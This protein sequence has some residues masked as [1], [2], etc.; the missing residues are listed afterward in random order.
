MSLDPTRSSALWADIV[1]ILPLLRAPYRNASHAR[2]GFF[3]IRWNRSDIPTDGIV[4]TTDG[5]TTGE[6][7]QHGYW[8]DRVPTGQVDARGNPTYTSRPARGVTWAQ[9][10][11]ALSDNATAQAT[12]RRIHRRARVRLETWGPNDASRPFDPDSA[13]LVLIAQ[14][15]DTLGTLHEAR[16]GWGIASHRTT[17]GWV[18]VQAVGP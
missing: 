3:P 18:A 15:L 14:Q 6:Y 5:D 17:G 9:A 4:A 8:S 7:H 11:A 10:R 2:G 1:S 13:G 12:L 16:L